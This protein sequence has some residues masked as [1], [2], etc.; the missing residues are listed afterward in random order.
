[1]AED[2]AP[3]STAPLRH[4]PRAPSNKLFLGAL[5]TLATLGCIQPLS[6]KPYPL[7]PQSL[8]GTTQTCAAVLDR[9]NNASWADLV[10]ENFDSG[11]HDLAAVRWY[12]TEG[13]C[14]TNNGPYCTD[15]LHDGKDSSD[16]GAV[17]RCPVL[18]AG[19]HQ[20]CGV[21]DELSNVLLSHAMGSDQSHFQKLRNFTELLRDHDHLHDLQCWKYYVNT[22]KDYQKYSDVCVLTD[23]AA[24]ASLRILGAYGIACA[25]QRRGLWSQASADYC[26]D[27]LKQGNA[28]WEFGPTGHGEIKQLQNGRFYLAASF[29]N[30]PWAPTASVSFRPDYYELQ[31]LMDFA[32]YRRSK[33][34]I[35]G[36]LDMLGAYAVSMGTNHIH[37]GKKGHFDQDAA[38]YFCDEGPISCDHPYMD[39]TDTWR[40]IPALGGLLNVHPDLVPSG[41]RSSIFDYWWQHFSGGHPSLYGPAAPKPREI[42]ANQAD[43]DVKQ[44]YDTYQTLPM[45]VPLAA[46]YD[47]GYV[48]AAIR[49][50]VDDLYRPDVEHFDLAAYYGGYYSQFA[51]RA[52]GVATGMIDP[53]LWAGSSFYTIAPCRLFDSRTSPPILTSGSQRMVGAAGGSCPVPV[54]AVA[55]AANV[56]V[57]AATGSGYLA[58]WP[59]HLDRPATSVINFGAGRTIANNLVV[60]LDDQGAFLVEPAIAASGSVH[61][62]IDLSGYF[63]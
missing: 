17:D 10:D 14:S 43:G 15:Q 8:C 39:N 56:T 45:W 44:A 60:G 42:Y 63:Q 46:A 62:I 35:Q 33:V 28:I 1:M 12:T 27:Y 61:V 54:S 21:T 11:S 38:T 20:F 9:W 26:A 52:I 53:E 4:H 23:S 40:A 47:P 22:R 32:L 29:M 50:L 2:H 5:A 19:N 57:T 59:A 34:M 41:L 6:A 25:K 3:F 13:T 55:V 51:Q 36:V 18:Q 7:S 48:I 49:H 31:F 24:D 37:R 58:I 30:Q 16:P